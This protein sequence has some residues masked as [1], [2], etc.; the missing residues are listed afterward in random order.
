MDKYK[1]LPIEAL[2]PEIPKDKVEEGISANPQ[3]KMNIIQKRRKAELT[4]HLLN[5]PGDHM[6][7][8]FKSFMHMLQ[9]I[10]YSDEPDKVLKCAR[11]AKMMGEYGIALET[12]VVKG[13]QFFKL[14]TPPKKPTSE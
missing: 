6:E 5:M 11:F 9:I 1:D 3:T 12:L 10:H 2:V 8:W 14:P 4:K 7:E 13:A